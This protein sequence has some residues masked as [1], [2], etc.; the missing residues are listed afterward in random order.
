ML[1]WTLWAAL[2][3]FGRSFA[4]T[5]SLSSVSPLGSGLLS[6]KGQVFVCCANAPYFVFLHLYAGLYIIV[7]VI[8]SSSRLLRTYYLHDL[9]FSVYTRSMQ[10][11]VVM[12]SHLPLY[13]CCISPLGASL[14]RAQANMTSIFRT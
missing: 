3:G 14:D 4:L 7:W 13:I 2:S 12:S 9:C 5:F 1:P 6:R 11:Q 8:G 10:L